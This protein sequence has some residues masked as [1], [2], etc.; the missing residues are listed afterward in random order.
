MDGVG[1]DGAGF[2]ELLDLG[3]GGPFGHGR[4]GVEVGGAV[5]EDEVTVAVTAGG[6][7]EG[8]VGGDGLLQDVRP[9]A[10][11][12]CLLGRGG[13]GDAA[14]GAVA[15]GQSAVGD[16][17]ADP[18]RGVEGGDAGAAGAQPFGE[19]ALRG[20]FHFQFTGE[21]LAGELL[22]LADVGAGHSDDAAGRQQDAEALAV[23]AAVV[24]DHA[25]AAGALGVQSADEHGGYAA[26]PEAAHRQRRLF[27][28]V[29]D[30]VGGRGHD[31]V[32]VVHA[33]LRCRTGCPAPGWC[34]SSAHG[35]HR[36]RRAGGRG[37]GATP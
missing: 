27:R 8:K 21:V 14:V 29:D 16:L 19:G 31:F 36:L 7:Y 20:E 37:T 32:H 33:F 34:Q 1:V 3:D 9:A 26:Q 12:P 23:H 10:E 15:P 35:G 17:G 4:E 13:D 24:G 25:Q 28:Y 2:D 6:P 18:G 5:V 11:L 30:R 22:V